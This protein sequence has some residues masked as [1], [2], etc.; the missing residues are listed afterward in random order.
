MIKTKFLLFL[1]TGLING[2][3]RQYEPATASLP[4]FSIFLPSLA[5]FRKLCPTQD[6]KDLF[7]F[8]SYKYLRG[9]IF[10]TSSWQ[11]Y[12]CPSGDTVVL[13]HISKS[14]RVSS[15]LLA[16]Y[17]LKWGP[18]ARSWEDT[19]IYSSITY[20][21][22]TDA[23]QWVACSEISGCDESGIY[24]S[25]LFYFTYLCLRV[26]MWMYVHVCEGARACGPRT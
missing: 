2:S 7:S 12:A 19:W 8:M 4:D 3:V 13:V 21:H 10:V 24:Y 5:F 14:F 20:F 26:S 17:K 1:V 15:P 16:D 25:W 6:S 11:Q 22:H 23:M 18:W 9:R